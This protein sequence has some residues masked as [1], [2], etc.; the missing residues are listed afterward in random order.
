M[1]APRGAQHRVLVVS[2]FF[3][4]GVGGVE[5]H[6][7]HLSHCL[8]K[9]GHK[10]RLTRSCAL[11]LL[12]VLVANRAVPA[13]GSADTR[14]RC[15]DWRALAV[16]RG[17][18]KPPAACTQLLAPDRAVVNGPWGP[19]A[20]VYYAPRRTV[21]LQ[22]TLPTVFGLL[23]LLRCIVLREG[24]TLVHAHQAFS[25]MAHEAVLH[26]RTLGCRVVF[27]DHSLFGFADV[28]SILTNKC[29]KFAAASV[30]QVCLISLMV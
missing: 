27:T 12:A 30:H 3:F 26:A 15:Q 5:S 2:D 18:G 6:I 7:Y 10:V 20:Q 22:V 9:Q 11:S 1:E 8:V 16:Q 21:Y 4:P 14:P 17:Q 19:V 29:L 13:G 24:I 28:A 25:P 23:R